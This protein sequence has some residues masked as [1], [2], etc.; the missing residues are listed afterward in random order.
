MVSFHKH[1]AGRSYPCP[2]SEH[3][4]LSNRTESVCSALLWMACKG[5]QTRLLLFRNVGFCCAGPAGKR[6]LLGA[7]NRVNR[8]LEVDVCLPGQ[9]WP[10][11][12]RD[13]TDLKRRLGGRTEAQTTSDSWLVGFIGLHRLCVGGRGRAPA[14]DSLEPRSPLLGLSDLV[15]F[16]S[17]GPPATSAGSVYHAEWR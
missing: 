1:R 5:V 10:F 14:Q 12:A 16:L 11:L 2:R 8:S 7:V 17:A 3:L 6:S 15:K 9:T 4:V 13:R